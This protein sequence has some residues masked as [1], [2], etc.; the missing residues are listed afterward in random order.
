[1]ESRI[2]ELEV[3]LRIANAK[4]D[5]ALRM[6]RYLTDELGRSGVINWDA[7]TLFSQFL[8]D[9][10]MDVDD[11]PVEIARLEIQPT[12]DDGSEIGDAIDQMVADTKTVARLKREILEQIRHERPSPS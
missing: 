5:L 8:N 6:V 9:H 1:M 10:A 3:D 2:E 12:A 7:N 4:A 11:P